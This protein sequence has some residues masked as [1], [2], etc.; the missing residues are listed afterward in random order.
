[1]MS[2]ILERRENSVRNHNKTNNKFEW[3]IGCSTCNVVLRNGTVEN[4]AGRFQAQ[5]RRPKNASG[6]GKTE[7][8][9][10]LTLKWTNQRRRD[11]VRQNY[12]RTKKKESE[13][14]EVTENM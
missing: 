13:K 3:F 14:R 4:V 7:Y 1:M 2:L 12:G 10:F 8:S 6:E 5:G 11:E 9:S